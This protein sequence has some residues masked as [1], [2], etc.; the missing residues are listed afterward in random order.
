ETVSSPVSLS[1]EQKAVL[2][3]KGNEFFNQGNIENALR[4]FIATGYSDGLTRIAD[5]Y[6]KENKSLE[7]LKLYIMAHNERRA[8][9][10]YSEIAKTISFLLN[11]NSRE[12]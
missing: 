9:P 1:S 11:E 4:I 10:L 3:R 2:N 5:L 8:S 12:E 6:A 7:A